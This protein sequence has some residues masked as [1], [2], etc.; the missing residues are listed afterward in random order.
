MA[1]R[2]QLTFEDEMTSQQQPT[3]SEQTYKSEEEEALE[4]MTDIN[5]TIEENKM[6]IQS[7]EATAMK[8][9]K[10]ARGVMVEQTERGKSRKTPQMKTRIV[11]HQA[12]VE[13]EPKL[14][15]P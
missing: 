3:F 4:A 5:K 1:S 9:T 7:T 13:V 2:K 8:Q 6:T 14:E 15:G 12:Q 11:H 10:K